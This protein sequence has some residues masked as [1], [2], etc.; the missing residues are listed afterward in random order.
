MT[1]TLTHFI[2]GKQIS[3][4]GALEST[5]SL[6]H[7]RDRRQVPRRQGRGCE[8]R[9]RRRPQ[10]LPG[11]VGRHAG[12]PRR[13]ARQGRQHDH[14]AQGCAGQAAGD[15]KKARPCRKPPARPCAPA[16]S[17]NISPARRCAATA[18]IWNSVRPGVEIQTYREAVGV[19]GLI[20]PWNFPIAIPAWKIAPALAFGNTVVLKSAN[21][22]PATAHALVSIIHEAG[23]PAGVVNMVLGRGIVGD[24]LSKHP[25]VNG[26][27]FTGSQT[28]GAKVAQAALSHSGP[29]AD[30]NGRQESAG[31]AGRCRIRP[32]RADRGG[33]R[34]F[35]HRPALHRFFSRVFVQEGIYDKFIDGV[36]DRAK[37]LKVG[38]ALD[39]ATQMGPAVTDTQLAG[40]LK[41]VDI[42]REG[43][44]PAA[45]R[46]RRAAEAGD[47]GP[48]YEPDPDRGHQAR[49]HHQPG[50][51][52]RPRRVGGEDQEL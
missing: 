27:S 28:V 38:D 26:V 7:Q 9:G 48:L 25:D 51:S 1:E 32:R 44:R 3:A 18:R 46:R 42:A 2:G 10:R 45:G 37:A 21:P 40:N 36:A 43:R 35:R 41:Y 50:R 29:R 30:G 20:T 22:T 13:P 16:A 11:L 6:Q 12:S 47:P 49:R 31:G 5:Q 17:S 52:V 24:A 4:P 23:A 15:A 19:Y 33:W 8:R 34:L 14:R 39:P